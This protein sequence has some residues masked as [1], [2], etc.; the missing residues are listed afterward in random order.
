[1]KTPI[2]ESDRTEPPAR[3]RIALVPPGAAALDRLAALDTLNPARR[4]LNTLSGPSRRSMRSNLRR[5]ARLLNCRLDEVPWERLRADHLKALRAAMT[6]Q[7]LLPA[8]INVTLAA[9]RGV[10]RQAY[11]MRA[12][13]PEDYRLVARVGNVRGG[14]VSGAARALD[15]REVGALLEACAADKTPAGARDACLVALL[16]GAGLRRAEAVALRL[17][18]W[19]ARTHTLRVL[20][21]GNKE[22]LVYLEDGGARR[23]LLDWLKV[24]GREP[25]ALLVPVAAGGRLELRHLT[26]QAVYD[27]VRKRRAQA[28]IRRRFSPH[29]LR[30][31][32]ADQAIR[33]G[34]E[35]K[36]VSELLGHASVQTTEIYYH[37]GER[38]KRRAAATV[39]LPYGAGRGR[40]KRR[41]RRRRRS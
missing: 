33:E 39:R 1:M 7:G 11:E 30:H 31:F 41:R 29:A 6:D 36:A 16:A 25:G 17:E 40:R 38:A 12:M 21:K 4:Y 35:V 10:A 27:A 15:V 19:R 28:S 18:D 23:A 9:L 24:R 2:I 20:G 14:R 34:G 13:E 8:T 32:F 22:R 37:G 26:G 5:V 3:P